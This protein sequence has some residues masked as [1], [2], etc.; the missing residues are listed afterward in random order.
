VH[1]RD[2]L[3]PEFGRE[4][5]QPRQARL[6]DLLERERRVGVE[7]PTQQRM[8]L[9]STVALAGVLLPMPQKLVGVPYDARPAQLADPVDHFSRARTHEREIAAVN[10]AIDRTA[11]D[12]VDHR[13][14]GGEVP[15][16]VADDTESHGVRLAGGSPSRQ[17]R[18]PLVCPTS[19]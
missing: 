4:G 17:R 12:V 18:V 3:D 10:H 16:Y 19:A 14:E 13:L 5:S 9:R 15:V 7:Q 11:R 1:D 2:S 8:K 6:A